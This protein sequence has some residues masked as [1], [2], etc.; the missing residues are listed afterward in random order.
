MREED[1]S[2]SA[3]HERRLPLGGGGAPRLRRDAR[4][5][6]RHEEHPDVTLRSRTPAALRRVRRQPVRDFGRAQPGC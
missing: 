5:E 2:R 4:A 3:T 1:R 6:G